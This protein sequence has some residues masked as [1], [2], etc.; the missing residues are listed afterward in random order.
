MHRYNDNDSKPLHDLIWHFI[1]TFIHSL[2]LANS[3]PMLQS[4]TSSSST[5]QSMT[6]SRSQNNKSHV[7]DHNDTSGLSGTTTATTTITTTTTPS[8]MT[9]SAHVSNFLHYHSLMSGGESSLMV[10]SASHLSSIAYPLGGSWSPPASLCSP[11]Y[12]VAIIIPYRDRKEH[13]SLLLA[14]LHP[15]LQL[16]LLSYTIYVVEQVSP[17]LFE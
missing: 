17:L 15:L 16:Q 6:H 14:H 11:R 2:S 8:S 7:E 5:H 4:T 10:S 9:S 12:R 3:T 13:L 1:F